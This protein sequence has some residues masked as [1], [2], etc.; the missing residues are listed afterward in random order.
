[1]GQ[2]CLKFLKIKNVKNELFFVLIPITV[3]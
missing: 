1:M 2:L 3:G